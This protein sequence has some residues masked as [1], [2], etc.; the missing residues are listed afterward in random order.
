MS[1]Y[2][3]D[4]RDGLTA[5]LKARQERHDSHVRSRDASLRTPERLAR[6]RSHVDE[7]QAALDAHIAEHGPDG[8]GPK[9]EEFGVFAHFGG[10]Q[11]QIFIVGGNAATPPMPLTIRDITAYYQL[12][13]ETK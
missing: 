11:H 3:Q 5:T 7:A 9:P 8:T 6:L 2:S 13:E 12:A 4:V 10:E 1:R